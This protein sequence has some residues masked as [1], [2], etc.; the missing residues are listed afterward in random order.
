MKKA[1]SLTGALGILFGINNLRFPQALWSPTIGMYC[2]EIYTIFMN[3]NIKIRIGF[4]L[5]TKETAW[6]VGNAVTGCVLVMGQGRNTE[7]LRE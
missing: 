2:L 3:D 7:L 6:Q 4:K 1:R 5:Y